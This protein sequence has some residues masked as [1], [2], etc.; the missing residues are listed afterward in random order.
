MRRRRNAKATTVPTG[1][2][3]DTLASGAAGPEGDAQRAETRRLL[4]AHIG[5]LP[6]P[7]RAVFVLRAVEELSVEETAAALGIP[8]ATVRTRYFRARGLLRTWMAGDID[9]TL[10]DAFAFAGARCDR[11]VRTVLTAVVAVLAAT[12][13]AACSEKPPR[14]DPELEHGYN[15]EKGAQNLLRERTVKQGESG[16]MSY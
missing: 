5:A 12:T 14:P 4:E 2:E 8:H 7:F 16:R 15:D 10:G 3:P 6:D 9:P 1:V 13:I 11:I